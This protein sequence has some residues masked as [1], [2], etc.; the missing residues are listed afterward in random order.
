MYQVLVV[1]D[2]VNVRTTVEIMLEKSGHC[3]VA[4]DS[5]ARALELITDRRFDL[6]ILDIWMPDMNGISV[7]KQASTAD[8][9]PKV[10]AMTGGNK[11]VPLMPTAALA[12]TWG[13]GKVLYKPFEEED[14]S[15]AMTEVMGAA[16]A[17]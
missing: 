8:H 14:L 13:A 12:E 11:Q 15:S 10:I 7:L 6:V 3:V 16:S 9:F 2:D 5:G 1:D 17:A 4:A